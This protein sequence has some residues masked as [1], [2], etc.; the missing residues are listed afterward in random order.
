ML[1][2]LQPNIC[3]LQV[4]NLHDI[5]IFGL[6]CLYQLRV[7]KGQ[8]VPSVTCLSKNL[9]PASEWD[10]PPLPE[11]SNQQRLASPN[12]YERSGVEP[13][14]EVSGVEYEGLLAAIFINVIIMGNVAVFQRV[15]L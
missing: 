7:A 11:P 6:C 5:N 8:S 4:C 13:A 10:Q 9:P 12:T 1:F 3:R 14:E 15:N 2:C